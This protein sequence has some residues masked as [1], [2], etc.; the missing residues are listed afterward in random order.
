MAGFGGTVKLTGETEY[1]RA[2]REITQNL[3]EISSEMKLANSAFDKN[4]KS[5]AAAAARA[6]VLTKQLEAQEK[7]VATLKAQYAEMAKTQDESSEAMSRMRVAINNAEADANKTANELDRLGKEAVESGTEASKSSEFWS[8]FS[9][10]LLNIGTTV[11][12]VAIDGLK[13]LGM[14][15]INV[16]KQAIGSYA[17]YEQLV[18][19]VETLFG[20]SADKVMDYA[21]NAYATAGV[22]A[23]E[24]MS[25][26]TSFSASL[27]SSLNGDTAQ[28]AEVGNRAITDMADNANKMGTSLASLQNAYQGFAKQNYTMLDNLKLGYGGTK[29]EME[30]LIADAA[31]LKDEQRELGVTIDGTSLSFANIVNAISVTQ[32]H[33]GI[34]GTT[35]LEADKTISGSAGSMKA[36]WQ[37]MLIGM[38]DSTADFEVLATNFVNSL[39]ATVQNIV[40]RIS[41]VI[42][43]IS[44]TITTVVPKLLQSVIPIIQ[45]NLPLIMNAVDQ[46]IKSILALIPQIMPVVREIIPDIVDILVG[47]LPQIVGSGVEIVLAL[48]DGIASAIPKLAAS[49]PNVVTSIINTLVK[50]LPKILQTGIDILLALVEGILKAIPQM[51]SKL[52]QIINTIISTLLGMIPQIVQTGVKLLVAL[53]QNIPAIISGLCAALPQIIHGLVSGIASHT[54]EIVKAGVQLLVALVQN[55]PAIISGI[56]SAVPQIISALVRGL[57]EGISQMANVGVNLVKGLWE[58]IGSATE[59]LLDQIKGFGKKV[60]DGVKKFFGIKSPSRLFRDEIGKNLALGI[61][62]GF[63]DEMKTVTSE[64]QNALPATLDTSVASTGASTPYLDMVMAFKEALYQVKIE[65]DDEVAGRFVEKTVADA[66]FS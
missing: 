48:I 49:I 39:M 37:N 41:Q 13:K 25:Q 45:E 52:P 2:L 20:Q 19:G 26:I 64:M 59:W 21:K 61:G 65:L 22:S 15:A 12:T 8:K 23:N 66:I 58:G 42:S 46:A 28:A 9:Q 6:E 7:K 62:E 32:K 53:V 16:G 31:L 43:G 47:M 54:G 55:M 44:Q 10:V 35:A 40:P 17:E 30:R 38:A 11:V 5:T 50:L 60:M 3:K 4:D 36:A 27:I 34:M 29:T 57:G 56:L 18:G 24:Y 1:R 14:A 51:V 63:T 33:M